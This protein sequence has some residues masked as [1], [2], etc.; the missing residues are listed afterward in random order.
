LLFADRGPQRANAI[1]GRI[2]A[3]VDSEFGLDPTD[4]AAC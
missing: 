1:E 3:D 4:A 2:A